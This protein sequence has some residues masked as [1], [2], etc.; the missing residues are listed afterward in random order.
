ML[1]R[2]L[3]YVGMPRLACGAAVS[4]YVGMLLLVNLSPLIPY[5]PT[6]RGPGGGCSIVSLASMLRLARRLYSIC[7]VPSEKVHVVACL[8]ASERQNMGQF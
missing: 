2:L 3:G 5:P 8:L 1:G 6:A 4:W 7:I